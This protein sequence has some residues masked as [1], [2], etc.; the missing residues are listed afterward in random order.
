M[1]AQYTLEMNLNVYKGKPKTIEILKSAMH[2]LTNDLKEGCWYVQKTETE[3]KV[4][5]KFWS[6]K[7]FVDKT[8]EEHTAKFHKGT[9]G[10]MLYFTEKVFGTKAKQLAINHAKVTIREK[11]ENA[12][13]SSIEND[14]FSLK[15]TLGF[16][17]I[18]D[19]KIL[20]VNDSVPLS[21][22]LQPRIVKP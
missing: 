22:S 1:P 15:N 2:N 12:L 14:L 13:E 17:L 9:N 5:V 19:D 3:D 18:K 20:F 8:L 6:D 7:Q 11:I 16:S 21:Q 10:I 4:S